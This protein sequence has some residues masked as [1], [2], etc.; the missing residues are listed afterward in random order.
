MRIIDTCG[1]IGNWPFRKLSKNT[2]EDVD[3]LCADIGADTLMLGSSN[4]VFYKNSY[5]GNMEVWNALQGKDLKTKMLPMAMINPAYTRWEEDAKFFIKELGFFGLEMAPDYQGCNFATDGAK[6]Y[7]L[8]SELG[9]PLRI[10]FEFE[11]C[12]GAHHM[13]VQKPSIMTAVLPMLKAGDGTLILNGCGG[14]DM[15]VAKAARER[16]NIFVDIFR[17]DSFAASGLEILA[18]A[19]TTDQLC[20]GTR[21]PFSYGEPNLVKLEYCKAFSDE[22]REKIAWKNMAKIVK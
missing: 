9:V 22:D 11:N 16:G 13:D 14:V 10:N 21:V 12:R 7:R 18:D 19:F 8:A 15:D 3:A 17:F 20:I 6:L 4:A 5:E 1:Y 2:I